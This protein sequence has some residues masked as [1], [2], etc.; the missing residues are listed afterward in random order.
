MG[1]GLLLCSS[2][3]KVGAKGAVHGE[4]APSPTPHVQQD[5][6]PHARQNLL[7][8]PYLLPGRDPYQYYSHS[9]LREI[10]SRGPTVSAPVN[11]VNTRFLARL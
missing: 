10:S 8:W 3:S 4:L 11:M 6:R 5:L 2:C 1:H 7:C 9:V